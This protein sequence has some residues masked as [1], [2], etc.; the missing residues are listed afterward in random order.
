MTSLSEIG[1][2]SW[3]INYDDSMQFYLCCSVVVCYCRCLHN[4]FPGRQRAAAT[5]SLLDQ[6][7]LE[8]CNFPTN[9]TIFYLIN[10]FNITNHKLCVDGY[11]G[12]HN[13]QSAVKRSGSDK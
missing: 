7:L 8:N 9:M 4:N 10:T 2:T 3:K 5:N 1:K 6:V 12:K 11:G 13:Q